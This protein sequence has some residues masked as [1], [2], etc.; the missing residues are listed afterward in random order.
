VTA[1]PTRGRASA[2]TASGRS[3]GGAKKPAAAGSTSSLPDLRAALDKALA[4]TASVRMTLPMVGEVMLPSPQ[5]LVFIA[6]VGVLAVIGA[7]EWPVAAVVVTGHV[8][9][10]GARNKTIQ[11]IGEALQEA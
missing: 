4:K 8:L 5:E 9:A 1:T 3:A 6:G 2:A 11:E 10:A 7:L